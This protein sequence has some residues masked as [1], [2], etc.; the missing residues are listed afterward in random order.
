MPAQPLAHH[1][2]GGE[3]DH[4]GRACQF[5]LMRHEGGQAHIKGHVGGEPADGERD[6]PAEARRIDEK[7]FGNPIEGHDEMAE[8]PPP[9]G[10]ETG[11]CRAA[12]IDEPDQPG[13]PDNQQGKNVK[14]RQRQRGQQPEQQGQAP[15]SPAAQPQDARG[16]PGQRA[17]RVNLDGH[18][19]RSS[20]FAGR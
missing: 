4:L 1:P 15:A 16:G 14:G 10:A 11:N 5:Q 19:G 3:G 8:A 7:G 13:Q 18:S 6:H 17:G 9:A 20:G 2:E 12:G